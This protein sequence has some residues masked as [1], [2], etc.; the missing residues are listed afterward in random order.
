MIEQVA[1]TYQ[2]VRSSV[3]HRCAVVKD[4]GHTDTR[5]TVHRRFGFC[6]RC[7]SSARHCWH[8]SGDKT[9]FIVSQRTSSI[10]FADTS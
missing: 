9:I 7:E 6:Y 5:T 8:A 3:L 4:P 10:Q 2:A 1:R